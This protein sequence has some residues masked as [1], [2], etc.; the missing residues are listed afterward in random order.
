MI[1]RFFNYIF[2]AQK[3][4]K[5]TNNREYEIKQIMNLPDKLALK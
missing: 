2:N 3:H 5:Q 4:Q 1:Y